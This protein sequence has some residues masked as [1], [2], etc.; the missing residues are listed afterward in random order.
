MEYM[1]WSE[2]PKAV[3]AAVL[4]AMFV[5]VVFGACNGGFDR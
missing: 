1:F 5:A 3:A 4:I 2:L